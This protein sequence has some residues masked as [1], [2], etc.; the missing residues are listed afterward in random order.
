MTTCYVNLLRTCLLAGGGLRL[1]LRLQSSLPHSLTGRCAVVQP[2]SEI[3]ARPLTTKPGAAAYPL[4]VLLCVTPERTLLAALM[5]AVRGLAEVTVRDPGRDDLSDGQASRETRHARHTSF[6][7]QSQI[8]SLHMLMTIMSLTT[9]L[10][11][12]A[13]R[14]AGE[15]SVHPVDQP[16]CRCSRRGCCSPCT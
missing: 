3:R 10:S 16:T 5:V 6:T 4:V 9:E 14:Q 2:R 12:K 7:C 15:L 13:H 1:L 11:S 8:D